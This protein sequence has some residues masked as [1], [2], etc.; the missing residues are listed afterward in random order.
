MDVCN[1]AL[2]NLLLYCYQCLSLLSFGYSS[3]DAIDETCCICSCMYFGPDSDGQK[4]IF[5]YKELPTEAGIALEKC[6]KK[7]TPQI[8][9]W[10]QYAEAA[11]AIGKRKWYGK[12][13]VA[14]YMPDYTRCI[15]HFCLHAGRCCCHAVVL[16]A[17]SRR[18]Q[19]PRTVTHAPIF[20]QLSLLLVTGQLW[21]VK[22]VTVHTEVRCP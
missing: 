12:D 15:D 10:S 6:L 22:T 1:A 3:D 17:A 19:A 9:S 4:G 13:Q 20:V 14:P 21:H 11:I 18:T 5:L 2:H 16:C 8:M 7:I